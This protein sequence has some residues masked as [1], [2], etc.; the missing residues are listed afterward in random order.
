[1]SASSQKAAIER[2]EKAFWKSI[3]DGQPKTATEL[4]AEPA[5][6][7][8]AHGV[9]KFDHAAYT[10]MASSDRM[11]LLD[12]SISEMDVLFPTDDVAIATYRVAQTVE[13]DGRKT[14]MDV[15][16]S[17]TWLKVE[18]RWQCVMH[19]ESPASPRH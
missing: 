3:V 2:L 13:A 7:V 10:K 8:S 16:D 6:M 4:L 1:M 5:L 18:D 9:N 14:Q 12:Y 19:T 11:K 17:S 15:Y